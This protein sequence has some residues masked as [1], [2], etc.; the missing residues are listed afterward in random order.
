M[1][2]EENKD[3]NQADSDEHNGIREQ[4]PKEKQELIVQT[5]ERPVN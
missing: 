3:E 4:Q 5:D 1:K 2:I